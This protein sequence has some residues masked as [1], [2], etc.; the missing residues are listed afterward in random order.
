MFQDLLDSILINPEESCQSCLKYYAPP[1]GVLV[2]VVA[3]SPRCYCRY[4]CV[5]R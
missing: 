5:A 3:A 4:T 1:P 2:H